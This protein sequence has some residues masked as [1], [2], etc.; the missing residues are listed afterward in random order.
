MP[1]SLDLEEKKAF[2]NSTAEQQQQRPRRPST[3]DTLDPEIQNE[4]TQDEEAVLE[5][6]LPPPPDG[7]LHA[8]LKVFGGFLIYINIW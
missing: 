6:E 1:T 7:G 8:W 2:E 3:Q 5:P 4:D